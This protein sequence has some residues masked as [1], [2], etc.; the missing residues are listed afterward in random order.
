M[1]T[2]LEKYGL[3]L[4]S[5]MI[6]QEY[7]DLLPVF[8]RMCELAASFLHEQIKASGLYITAMESRV[9]TEQ[10]LAGKLELKGSKYSSLSDITDVLG[11]RVITFYTDEVDKISA[12]VEKLFDVDW[13]ESVDK[14]KMHEL[15]SFGYN[16]LHYI[17]RIPKSLFFD[18]EMP[19]I[20]T[21]R[22]ELQMRTA[23]QHVW[24]TMYHDTGYKSGIEVPREYIRNLNRI[25]GMLELA[26]EQ[27][28]NIRTSINDYR[29]NVQNLVAGGD[30]ADVPLDADTFRSYIQLGRLEPL[31]KRI[32]AINQAEIHRTT[33]L[34]YLDALHEF[35]FKT[36]Q[37]IENLIR[38]YS[39]DAYALAD[40][41]IRNTDLD[42]LSSTISIQKL[43]T[44][45]LISSGDVEERL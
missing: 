18:P 2:P 25:A 42:I 6:L 45:C 15:D 11:L 10:S 1:Q 24:A 34:P 5:E 27:F 4:H 23:L 40:N 37:D 33:L 19:E 7:R 28:S 39:Q 36:L 44:V 35:G 30:F 14:R 41:Q 32:A 12:V 43:L 31:V 38:D 21:L 22:F 3:D 20:N 29:R 9:K 16:S 26:D 13:S 17:C 8:E